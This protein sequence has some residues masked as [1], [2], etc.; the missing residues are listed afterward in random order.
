MVLGLFKGLFGGKG[1]SSGAGG[2]GSYYVPS[3]F[4]GGMEHNHGS[5]FFLMGKSTELDVGAWMKVNLPGG[6]FTAGIMTDGNH[7]SPAAPVAPTG[8]APAVAAPNHNDIN[9]HARTAAA[10]AA[11]R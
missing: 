7:Y 1:G 8:H 4:G 6:A 9:Q 10:A 3:K 11:A 5:P 2:L